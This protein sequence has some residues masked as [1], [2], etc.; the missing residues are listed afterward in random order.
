MRRCRAF[1]DNAFTESLE[2][3][4]QEKK[5]NLS[6]EIRTDDLVIANKEHWLLHNNP[7]TFGTNLNVFYNCIQDQLQNWFKICIHAKFV[8]NQYHLQYKYYDLK[9]WSGTKI[10]RFLGLSF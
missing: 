6:T 1:N 8:I 5:E 9:N 2:E 10:Y 3:K 4:I 7:V